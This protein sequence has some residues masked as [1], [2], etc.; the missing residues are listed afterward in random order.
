MLLPFLPTCPRFQKASSL[1][2]PSPS[3]LPSSSLFI[4]LGSPWSPSFSSS[5]SPRAESFASPPALAQY[6]PLVGGFHSRPYHASPLCILAAYHRPQ[7][8]A[9]AQPAR[10]GHPRHLT[11]SPTA[12][13]APA[14]NPCVL[15]LNLR[16]PSRPNLHY[17]SEAGHDAHALTIRFRG[18]GQTTPS[19]PVRPQAK[20]AC[21]L[22]A[23]L[24]THSISY[25]Y[26][27][28][29]WSTLPTQPSSLK[30]YIF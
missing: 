12:C 10:S 28:L 16:E 24:H 13:I 27:C 22:P 6:I 1:P 5:P 18:T 11:T 7:H 25:R 30:E 17:H 2:S 9:L 15:R 26:P 21:R 19:S 3:F 4:R 29:A 8:S 20:P 23:R 14:D